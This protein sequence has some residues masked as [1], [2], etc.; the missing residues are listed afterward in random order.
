MTGRG[1]EWTGGDWEVTGATGMDWEG[2]GGSIAREWGADWP[3]YWCFLLYTG[4][5]WGGYW[6]ILVYISLYW[7]LLVTHLMSSTLVKPLWV[8]LGAVPGPAPGL[9]RCVLVLT[10]LYWGLLVYNGGYWSL[11]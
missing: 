5:Y 10:G 1:L 3:S 4:L 8:V 9:Y 7:G 6:D 11:I 2:T